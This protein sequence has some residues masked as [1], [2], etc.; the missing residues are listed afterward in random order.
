M[1]TEM[2]AVRR[3]TQF[4]AYFVS[5][6]VSLLMAIAAFNGV[7]FFSMSGS[8]YGPPRNWSAI[9]IDSPTAQILWS[10]FFSAG[11]VWL[12]WMAYRRLKQTDEKGGAKRTQKKK[13]R[14]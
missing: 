13:G 5:G 2:D 6:L 14:R 9:A 3:V 1:A 11:C 7:T 8:K 10:G 4:V 12:F